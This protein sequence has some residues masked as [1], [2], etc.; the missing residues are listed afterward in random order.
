[1]DHLLQN[2]LDWIAL[3]PYAFSAVVFV[4]GC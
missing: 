2:V 4:G 1:M 3:H